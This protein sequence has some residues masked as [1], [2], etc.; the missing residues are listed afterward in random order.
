[1]KQFASLAWKW[2]EHMQIN[3]FSISFHTACQDT[4][5]VISDY[6]VFRTCL[7]EVILHLQSSSI[8]Y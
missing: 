4:V 7:L 1:M 5:C 3:E 2:Y 8:S 6:I